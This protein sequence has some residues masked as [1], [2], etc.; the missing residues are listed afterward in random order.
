MPFLL[1]LCVL[2]L[3]WLPATLQLLSFD[4]ARASR[5]TCREMVDDWAKFHQ[6][7]QQQ[8]PRTRQDRTAAERRIHLLGCA[9]YQLLDNLSWVARTKASWVRPAEL[10]YY[11]RLQWLSEKSKG[12]KAERMACGCREPLSH[13]SQLGE[14]TLRAMLDEALRGEEDLH[15][16]VVATRPL[17]QLIGDRDVLLVGNS[18]NLETLGPRQGAAIDGYGVVVRFNTNW[19]ADLARFIGHKRDVWVVMDYAS[20]CGCLTSRCCNATQER[21]MWERVGDAS[22]FFSKTPPPGFDKPEHNRTRVVTSFGAS[23]ATFNY[24]LWLEAMAHRQ[25]A[26]VLNPLSHMRSGMQALLGVAANGI[27]PTLAGF[28][29]GS[30]LHADMY[31][32]LA[33]RE[34]GGADRP[35]I[36]KYKE[37]AQVVAEMQAAGLLLLLGG[38]AKGRAA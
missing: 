30:A 22:L 9:A 4:P 18:D 16:L 26:S 28:D 5:L 8:A 38:K 17:V 7:T 31:E 13:A 23:A 37:E 36:V 27:V 29:V 12:R 2:V 11:R 20:A 25:L 21:A 33:A 1:L 15:K 3:G 24:W 10:P 14:P 35:P 19:R 32:E 6:S 34:A